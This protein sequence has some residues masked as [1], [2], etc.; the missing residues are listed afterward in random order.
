LTMFL[1]LTFPFS[2]LIQ[3]KRVSAAIES[4]IGKVNF[5]DLKVPLA[6]VATDLNT[7]REIVIR[8]GF[9]SEAVRASI[10]IPGIMTPCLIGKQWLVDGG[11]VNEVPAS[12]CRMAGISYVI[13][14]NVIPDPAR[15]VQRLEFMREPRLPL[16][17]GKL[18]KGMIQLR[19]PRFVDVMVQTLLITGYRVAMEN[20]EE[21]DLAISPDLAGIGFWEFHKASEAIALGEAAAWA[22]LK[23]A[24]H[25]PRRRPRRLR[26]LKR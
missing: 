14:V 5:T 21:T 4:L 10:A 13:G 7:G 20:L 19:P 8:K 24:G 2:G 22:A 25:L 1:D 11:I 6:C 17:S 15:V 18:K 23:Q 12:I 26:D 9:V 16:A 3:G